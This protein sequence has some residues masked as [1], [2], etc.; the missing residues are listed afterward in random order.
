MTAV[1][2][3]GMVPNEWLVRE[4]LDAG[5]RGM[6]D[7]ELVGPRIQAE[8]CYAASKRAAENLSELLTKLGA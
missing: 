5:Y 8:G 3:D 2:G 7:L 4:L 1:P 6:F